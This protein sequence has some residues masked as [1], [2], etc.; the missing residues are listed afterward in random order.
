MSSRTI[1]PG[2]HRPQPVG[3]DG[4][5]ESEVPPSR[6]PGTTSGPVGEMTRLRSRTLEGQG[7]IRLEDDTVAAEAEGVYIRPMERSSG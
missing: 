1:A 6:A 5:T 3:G 7:E 4:Q 2:G